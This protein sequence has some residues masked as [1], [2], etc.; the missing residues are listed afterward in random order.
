MLYFTHTHT[1]ARACARRLPHQHNALPHHSPTA[2]TIT[3]TTTTTQHKGFIGGGA[4]CLDTMTK[5]QKDCQ[6][7]KDDAAVLNG[8][9]AGPTQSS[10]GSDYSVV[11]TSAI[12]L[13]EKENAADANES[14]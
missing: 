3:T 5:C 2:T 10:I 1:R 9:K 13:P 11:E 7:D 8:A 14:L 6:K 12:A 4:K